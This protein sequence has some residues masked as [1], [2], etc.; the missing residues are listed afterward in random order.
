MLRGS[1]ASSAP[2][3]GLDYAGADLTQKAEA[4]A[5]QPFVLNLVEVNSALANFSPI[6]SGVSPMILVGDVY[7][8]H[9]QLRTNH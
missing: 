7:P 3:S 1:P 6:N 2:A 9:S 4:L 8:R 5:L